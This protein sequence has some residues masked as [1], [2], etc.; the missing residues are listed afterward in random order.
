MKSLLRQVFVAALILC[1]S[2]MFNPISIYAA[3]SVKSKPAKAP[4]WVGSQNPQ[5]G[6]QKAKSG[7]QGATSGQTGSQQK[8]KQKQNTGSK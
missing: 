6:D 7:A 1:V 8:G 3:D 2:L 5:P 4:D